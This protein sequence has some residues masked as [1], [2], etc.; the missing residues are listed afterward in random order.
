M[1]VFKAAC[2]QL[3]SS[4]DPEENVRTASA[5]IREAKGQGARF[6]CDAR[7]HHTDG[8]RRRRQD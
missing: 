4:D 7:E 2:V 3:R 8:A 1:S 5:L 6:H